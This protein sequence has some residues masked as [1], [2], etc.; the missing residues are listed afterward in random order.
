METN[1]RLVA[2]QRMQIHS[3]VW[4]AVVIRLRSPPGS[5][6]LLKRLA[7]ELRRL[8]GCPGCEDGT[9]SIIRG[10]NS[11]AQSHE[12]LDGLLGAGGSHGRALDGDIAKAVL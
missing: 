2:P 6:Q 9:D 10:R 1:L 5:G 3:A 8:H 7:D 4:A 11:I 12:R